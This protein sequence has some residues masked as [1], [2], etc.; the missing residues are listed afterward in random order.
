MKKGPAEG[1][2]LDGNLLWG[3]VSVG[4]LS[5][6]STLPQPEQN[7][8][9]TQM[10]DRPE[11]HANSL[12]IDLANTHFRSPGS[13]WEEVK[14]KRWR[15]GP[16]AGSAPTVWYPQQRESF[17]LD[18]VSSSRKCAGWWRCFS[19]LKSYDSGKDKMVISL[20]SE[21]FIS[22]ANIS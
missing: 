10:L 6:I 8:V 21:G 14:V 16:S 13:G 22:F 19:I 9:W 20:S 1:E 17:M 7:R 4:Q 2:P 11:V 12:Q 3:M 18:L 5:P 15:S